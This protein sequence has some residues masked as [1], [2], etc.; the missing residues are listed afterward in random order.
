M[1]VPGRDWNGAGALRALALGAAFVAY[2]TAASAQQS[3]ASARPADSGA[4]Q[5]SSQDRDARARALELFEQ[6]GKAM[7]AQRYDEACPK[8][9]QAFALVPGKIGVMLAL[10]DCYAAAG[11]LASAWT[12]YVH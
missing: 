9:A 12:A 5:A 7:D 4:L 8:F 1:R 2:P 3:D 10:A 6:A 11:K